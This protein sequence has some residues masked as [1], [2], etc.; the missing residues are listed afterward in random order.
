MRVTIIKD[1][2][3]VI[4]DGVRF[5]VTSVSLLPANLHAVQWDS[6]AKRGELEWS[7]HHCETCGH[8]SKEP[9][10][11]IIE[12]KIGDTPL[13]PILDAWQAAKVAADAEAERIKAEQAAAVEAAKP[14]EP[15]K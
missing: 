9:N 15:V 14:A 13:Q 4:V 1:D 6:V 5:E 8:G 11:R 7:F 2:T 10:T 12:F 3:A